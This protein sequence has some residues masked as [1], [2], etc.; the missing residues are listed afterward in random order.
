MKHKPQEYKIIGFDQWGKPV[1]E[2]ITVRP[3]PLIYRIFPNWFIDLLRWLRIVK[4]T[5]KTIDCIEVQK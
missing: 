4:P 5:W 2:V 1:E 3:S